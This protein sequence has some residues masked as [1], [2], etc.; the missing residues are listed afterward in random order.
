MKIAPKF[1]LD[2][3]RLREFETLLS[4]SKQKMIKICLFFDKRVTNSRNLSLSYA[5]L[6]VIL[7]QSSDG[8]NV[9]MSFVVRRIL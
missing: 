3:E 4:K 9:N 6:G 7:G 1:A 5:K 2:N 8:E